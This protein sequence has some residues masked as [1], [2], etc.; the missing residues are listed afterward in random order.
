M[1]SN[2]IR[3]TLV[4]EGHPDGNFSEGN[5]D[6]LE[7]ENLNQHELFQPSSETAKGI[8]EVSELR[9]KLISLK[10]PEKNEIALLGKLLKNSF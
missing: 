4:S 7:T 2:Q 8:S 5:K 3:D 6:S 9:T 1:Q 10:Y